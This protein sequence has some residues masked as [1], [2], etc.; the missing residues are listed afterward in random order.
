MKRL[1]PILFLIPTLA[2]GAFVDFFCNAS[3]G[4]NINAGSDAG[5][6]TYTS[7]NG[8]WS[9]V[10]NIFTPTDGTNP[11]SA[12]VMVGQYA[13]IY[14]DGATLA[15]YIAKITAVT[16]AA[17][18][19]I[20][21]SSTLK[22][23]SAPTTSAT[24]RSIKVGGAW[25]GPNGAS[26]FPL[27]L[28]T[29]PNLATANSDKVCINLKNNASYVMTA[30]IT[31]TGSQNC[32][33][34]GYTTTVRD[35]GKATIDG[36]TSGASYTILTTSAS[37]GWS[38]IDL[39]FQN[40]GAS[41]STLA[42]TTQASVSFIRCVFSGMRGGGLVAGAAGMVVIECEAFGNNLSNTASIGGFMGAGDYQRCVS[43]DNTGS[44][45]A[46]FFTTAA[47]NYNNC[48][49][50]TNG[51]MGFNISP[52]GVNIRILNC[53]AYNN[54]SDGIRATS[55]KGTFWIENCNLIKNGG[56]G[57]NFATSNNAEH[58]IYK[59]GFGAGTQVNTSG[60]VTG[61]YSGQEIGSVTY[62]S[63][64][65]PWVDPANGDFRINLAT[66]N[67]AGRGAFTETASSYA[68]TVGFPDIGAAQSLTGPT[69]TFS[70]E[71]SYGYG[72]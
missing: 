11:V 24:G 26:G 50:D 14:V 35:G 37:T 60:T 69:G 58:F 19:T 55:S 21:V 53:D 3:T 1:V 40:N 20:T 48:I 52:S 49:S 41:G 9:T 25:K 30:G 12:G 46:G 5:T 32:Q 8:N 18:G 27:D 68:G 17:N 61:A 38:H 22:A 7:T 56:W 62:A 31:E 63:N 4:A 13:S 67:F 23:G 45:T 57:I 72:Q 47:T 70:K 16:N 10:T 33:V 59:C 65:T 29:L 34:Q 15:V 43:H 39:I 66:A 6:V 54:A 28:G 51:G 42:V 71:T 44:N 36:G 2:F 64:V